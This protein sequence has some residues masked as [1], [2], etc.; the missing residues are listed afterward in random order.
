[1]RKRRL[2]GMGMS[3]STAEWVYSWSNVALIASLIVGVLATWGVVTSSSVKEAASD[4]RAARLELETAEAKRETSRLSAEAEAAKREIAVANAEAAKA[5]ERANLAALETEKLKSRIAWRRISPDQKN[6]LIAA[7]APFKGQKIGITSVVGSDDG[8]SYAADFVEVLKAAGWVLKDGHPVQSI[9]SQIP[10]K[11]LEITLSQTDAD[12][13]RILRSADTLW[14]ALI[15]VGL[16]PT[17]G[18]PFKN[19]S[20]QEAEIELRVGIRP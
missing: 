4:E 12:A 17:D 9:Y 1:M 15:A 8:A 20:V 11:G 3:L 5:N 2:L 19:P 13:G 10:P 7:L 6:S 14:K 18:Q 16:M